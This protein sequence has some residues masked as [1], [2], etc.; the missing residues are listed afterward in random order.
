MYGATELEGAVTGSCTAT[1]GRLFYWEVDVSPRDAS[2]M[3]WPA[4]PW[5][6]RY[7]T[8]SVGCLSIK[9][10]HI[11]N[12]MFDIILFRFIPVELTFV[13]EEQHREIPH[14]RSQLKRE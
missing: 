14:M 7:Q 4:G 3:S 6:K 1:L 13:D 11:M 9:Q 10:T 5:E 2:F 8:T 12:K